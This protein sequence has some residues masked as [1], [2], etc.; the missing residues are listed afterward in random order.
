[1]IYEIWLYM[2]TLNTMFA[3]I[4]IHNYMRI[5]DLLFCTFPKWI[6]IQF[7]SWQPNKH[8]RQGQLNANYETVKALQNI[9]DSKINLAIMT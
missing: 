6:T 1:M 3:T 8:R 2:N 4:V 7:G 9:Q 5:A